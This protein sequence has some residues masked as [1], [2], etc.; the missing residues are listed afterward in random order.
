MTF[1][2]LH[3]APDEAEGE[4][5]DHDQWFTSL[6]AARRRRAEL[7]ADNPSLRGHRYGQDFKIERVELVQLPPQALLLAVLNG[8]G[9]IE[10]RSTVIE[11][12]K[13]ARGADE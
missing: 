2:R 10:Q 13:P 1:Y 11:N 9:Y 8:R 7:I 4:G 3:I 12:Y 5:E 6:R